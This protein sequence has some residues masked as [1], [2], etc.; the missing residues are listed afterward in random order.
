ME[1]QKSRKKRS[2]LWKS[3]LPI[4]DSIAYC[5]LCH[6]NISYKSSTTNLKKHLDRHPKS[7]NNTELE[8]DSECYMLVVEKED[9]DEEYHPSV[10]DWSDDTEPAI[11]PQANSTPAQKD[12]RKKSI[13]WNFFSPS[14]NGRATC[15]IC[16]H[17]LSHQS[18][19]SNLKKHMHRRHP[20]VYL[21]KLAQSVF[22]QSSHNSSTS[23]KRIKL[24]TGISGNASLPA[25][26]Q[27][28]SLLWKYFIPISESMANC[29]IC[30]KTISY[31][32]SITNLKKHLER[33]PS[34][35][36]P[37]D[38][39]SFQEETPEDKEFKLNPSFAGSTSYVSVTPEENINNNSN[40]QQQS[41]VRSPAR[42]SKVAQ[43]KVYNILLRIFTQDYQPFSIVEGEGF[44]NYIKNINPSYVLP[45]KK[46]LTQTLLSEVYEETLVEIKKA[47][48][49]ARSLTVT[50]ECWTSI[51]N[52]HIMS[53]T[54]H[55][56]TENFKKKTV[57][58][59]C[60]LFEGGYTNSDLV[61][62]LR[63]IM[64]EW[65][66]ENKV[67]LTIS[68]SVD[69]MSRDIKE[70][71]NWDNFD[72][73][74]HTL[75][76]IVQDGLKLAQPLLKKFRKVVAHFR[77][78]AT[79]G[80]QLATVLE[81]TGAPVKK[82][83]KDVPTRWNST[84]YMMERLLQLEEAISSATALLDDDT[85][86]AITVEEWQ[87]LGDIKK[88]LEPMES[89][90][91]M[92][93]S[94]DYVCI[95]SII[96]LTEGL[97]RVYKEMQKRITSTLPGN[98]IL[99]FLKGIQIR[100]GDLEISETLLVSTFLDPR[101]KNVGFSNET[102]AQA[103]KKIVENL[104]YNK[105]NETVMSLSSNIEITVLDGGDSSG[106]V[107]D[108][109]S[110]WGHFDEKAMAVQP[111]SN[112]FARA[113]EEVQR[114]LEDRLLERKG[115]PLLWWSER[116]YKYPYLKDVVIEKLGTTATSVPCSRLFSKA[117]QELCDRR[118]Q[119]SFNKVR[120]LVFLNVNRA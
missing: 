48:A 9:E 17:N 51:R 114:Y 106:N 75:S 6:K 21:P 42:K 92:M 14:G 23:A 34:V 65:G 98:V 19:T 89:V 95:S 18:S 53:V 4:N 27:K 80:T 66:L 45:S 39:E 54:V 46:F 31:K 112:D 71:L 73:Y 61:E 16:H 103:A 29:K 5:K 2:P 28:R 116:S 91:K 88:I 26:K 38:M 69:S 64:V 15:N 107:D 22:P 85:I 105:I 35:N 50:T 55:F 52:E 63:R 33:H 86:P 10:E 68:N 8:A 41:T 49:E 78:N 82:L 81:E 111:S 44:R 119:F 84:F 12:R 99:E 74:A 83:I 62:E 102:V 120:K 108:G 110:V 67:L 118:S 57:Q 77:D 3:F 94:Q 101:F 47:V 113:V 70:Q 43:S 59:D 37:K 72:C 115:D 36:I 93:S 1:G 13:L 30:R 96:I 87:L 20:T 25:N 40:A 79:A 76:T 117:G 56:I 104:V 24:N 100:L 90:T 32:T 58:L 60:A 7:L 109:F 97:E 11:S